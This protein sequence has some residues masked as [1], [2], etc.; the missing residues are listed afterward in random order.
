MRP[1]WS[2]AAHAEWGKALCAAEGLGPR[3]TVGQGLVQPL[4]G[5]AEN[6]KW[7]RAPLNRQGDRP[8]TPSGAGPRATAK[9]LSPERRVGQSYL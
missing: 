8:H 9:G 6:T 3:R 2:W 7:G 5:C 4:R 1:A